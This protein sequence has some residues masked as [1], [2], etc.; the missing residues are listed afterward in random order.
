MS[1]IGLFTETASSSSSSF[2]AG[3]ETLTSIKLASVNSSAMELLALQ[4]V[5]DPRLGILSY[6]PPTLFCHIRSLV[7]DFLDQLS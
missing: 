4:F 2:G 6:P 7:R 1:T 3:P 5:Q